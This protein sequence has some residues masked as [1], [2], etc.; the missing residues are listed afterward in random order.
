VQDSQDSVIQF[1]LFPSAFHPT[2]K[3]LLSNR[4][5]PEVIS[6]YGRHWSCSS[7]AELCLGWCDKRVKEEPI[8]CDLLRAGFGCVCV[9]VDCGVRPVIMNRVLVTTR[10]AHWEEEPCGG[11]AVPQS[12]RFNYPFHY[13]SYLFTYS[14]VL[15]ALHSGILVFS[16]RVW[17][18]G[19]SVLMYLCVLCMIIS[20]QALKFARISC[21]RLILLFTNSTDNNLISRM[22]LFT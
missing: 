10:S 8:D 20:F 18:V 3:T 9:C 14:G 2:Q 22:T 16:W 4:C 17:F 7:K 11:G 5:Y 12:E 19:Q 6:G 13:C 1:Y 21:Q 15:A